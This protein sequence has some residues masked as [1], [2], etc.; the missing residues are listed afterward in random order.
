MD[1][2]DPIRIEQ[3][4]HN[5]MLCNSGW[6][7][8]GSVLAEKGRELCSDDS[9]M[10]GRPDV[11]EKDYGRRLGWGLVDYLVD[12][13]VKD[14]L[15]SLSTAAL[16]ATNARDDDLYL[17]DTTGLYPC[18]ALAIGSHSHQIN[19]YLSKVDFM[20]LTVKDGAEKLLK[21]VRDCRQDKTVLTERERKNRKQENDDGDA[22]HIPNCSIVEIVTMMKRDG[23]PDTENIVVR[24][25]E[26]FLPSSV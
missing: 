16:L 14:S 22:W 4:D 20:K 25:K 6:R 17:V 8:D 26:V 2:I 15:R 18:R 23:I 11:Y 1:N 19:E 10:Y 24:Q 13:Y 9:A 5:A 3:L 7:V 21:I 12:C